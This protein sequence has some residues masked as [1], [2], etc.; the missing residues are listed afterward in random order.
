MLYV[1]GRW[2]DASDADV[3]W[4]TWTIE[5]IFS[6][7]ERAMQHALPGW[8]IGPVPLDEKLPDGAVDWPGLEVVGTTA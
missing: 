4:E 8:F 2:T 6:T 3:F 5:G 7:K 1:L